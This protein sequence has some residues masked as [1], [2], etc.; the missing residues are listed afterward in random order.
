LGRAAG[1]R[2]DDARLMERG[3][4][5]ARYHTRRHTERGAVKTAADML[6]PVGLLTPSLFP[7]FDP[8]SGDLTTFLD[9]LLLKGA[10]T[11]PVDADVN[12]ETV[13][14]MTL[15]Y[16]YALAYQSIWQRLSAAP[17][18]AAIQGEASSG[19]TASQ[20]DTFRQLY[21]RWLGTHGALLA[22]VSVDVNSVASG[23]ARPDVATRFRF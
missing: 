19:Y 23:T 7:Q 22:S 8:A 14:A 17:A 10:E 11:I 1:I 6:Q 21:E 13:D 12:P 15:A 2:A 5:L 3:G 4:P 20:I 18:T 9:N 16:A